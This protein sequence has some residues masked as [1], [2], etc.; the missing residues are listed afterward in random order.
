MQL[1]HHR[2][3]LLPDWMRLDMVG[4]HGSVNEHLDTTIINQTDVSLAATAL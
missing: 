3:Q 4:K 2:V 1:C